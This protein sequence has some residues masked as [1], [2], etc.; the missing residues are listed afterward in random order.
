MILLYI[1][2]CIA[3]RWDYILN[4]FRSLRIYS[5]FYANICKEKGIFPTWC[6]VMRKRIKIYTYMYSEIVLGTS[7][8]L[9]LVDIAHCL[10]WL[11]SPLR[12]NSLMRGVDKQ[13]LAFIG[14]N[15]EFWADLASRCLC[16]P[17]INKNSKT[18]CTYRLKYTYHPS[19]KWI[20]S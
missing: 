13:N 6:L 10:E 8:V 1:L 11:E 14:T 12:S 17:N 16:S 4:F 2:S 15:F 18:W 9:L 3:Y 5:I 19:Q 7:R 20:L